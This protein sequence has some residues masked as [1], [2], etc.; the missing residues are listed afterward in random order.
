MRLHIKIGGQNHLIVWRKLLRDVF[1]EFDRN[2]NG[3]LNSAEISRASLARSFKP[4]QNT[5]QAPTSRLL[6]QRLM[7]AD[8]APNDGSLTV[9]EF[10]A[11]FRRVGTHSLHIMQRPEA[12]NQ[13]TPDVLSILD[14]NNDRALLN[15]ELKD[16]ITNLRKLDLDDDGTLS[17]D[18]MALIAPNLL[19]AAKRFSIPQERLSRHQRD[20]SV[21]SSAAVQRASGF[22]W[23]CDDLQGGTVGVG[24]SSF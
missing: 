14:R 13:P 22:G 3:S 19:K 21:G 16:A 18:E 15:A 12:E 1:D 8:I 10:V 24:E 20:G 17:S 5:V 6:A 11:W 7:A 2:H 9:D 4:L 23:R